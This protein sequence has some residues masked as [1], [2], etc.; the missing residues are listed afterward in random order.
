MSRFPGVGEEFGH[1]QITRLLG[2]GGMGVVFAATD[3]RLNRE[4]A[5]KVLN[6]S[7]STD[8]E[9]HDRFNTEAATLAR[10]DSVHIVQVYEHGEIDGCLYLATQLI[11]GGDLSTRL[12]EG[13]AMSRDD[14]IKLTSQIC[15][16]LEDAH[17]A[18]VIHRDVKPAN[19]LLRNG[20][21]IHS[22]LCDFGIATDADTS[23]TR[24]GQVVGSLAYM[25]PERHNGV[26]GD[27]RADIYS[28]GC[29]LYACLSGRPPYSGTD[30]QVALGH[31]QREIPRL[32]GTDPAT[33]QIN[34]V[35]SRAL[36]KNP[37]DRYQTAPE[38]R[39]A[40]LAIFDSPVPSP[41][42]PP[43]LAH[44]QHKP[45]PSKPRA[46]GVP[47][48]PAPSRPSAARGVSAP[49]PPPY[50]QRRPPA[51]PPPVQTGSRDA[52]LKDTTPRRAR[53]ALL[54]ALGVV[55][56]LLLG[57]GAIWAISSLGDDDP[58]SADRV[59]PS[60]QGSPTRE[61]EKKVTRTP[62]TP[63]K[64]ALAQNDETEEPAPATADPLGVGYTEQN[65][66]CSG[67]LIVVLASDE[68]STP[69]TTVTTAL[70]RF[71]GAPDRYYLDPAKSC[72]NL[73]RLTNKTNLARFPY[74]GPSPT[75]W[76]PARRAWHRPTPRPT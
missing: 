42:P 22:Y 49:T 12:T 43:L 3:T 65:L 35:L 41:P 2:K 37:D 23:H 33:L 29:V 75:P 58:S 74:M 36:A 59:E 45:L 26:R 53:L 38:L 30:V 46:P 9:F 15:Q 54:V 52:T 73:S 60:P 19:I 67:E 7:L 11:R 1:F 25:A 47:P 66:P 32:P 64:P 55:L 70:G 10:V 4:V 40:L 39:Q 72:G 69:A 34:R 17:D 31:L 61:N 14:A 56:G 20:S 6:A 68:A 21:A 44:T 24:T 50:T 13:G 5:L 18:G 63:A 27:E 62:S 28:A 57:G 8:Q 16:A 51:T 76:P 48:A 71:P